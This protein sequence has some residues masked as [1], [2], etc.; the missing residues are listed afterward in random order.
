MINFLRESKA[1]NDSIEDNDLAAGQ[2]ALWY[3][4]FHQ[5]NKRN[6]AEWFPLKNS[7]LISHTGLS[8]SGIHKARNILKQKGYIDFQ[9]Q[10]RNKKTLYRLTP[11]VDGDCYEDSNKQSNNQ[12]VK[13]GNTGSNKQSATIYKHKTETIN[14]TELNLNKNAYARK[15]SRP[16]IPIYKLG[17]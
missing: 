7:Q 3:A 11:L 2:I 10:G 6:W 13:Q 8:I 12:G 9:P 4:L 1:F 5:D 14:T 16:V 17:E 15:G